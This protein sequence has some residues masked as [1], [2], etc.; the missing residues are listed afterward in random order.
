MRLRRALIATAVAVGVVSAVA[1][2]V[3]ATATTGD[4]CHGTTVRDV[5]VKKDTG[6]GTPAEWANL[7]LARTVTITCTGPDSYA[8][9]LVDRGA[10]VTIKG[11]GTPSGAG[12]QIEHTLPGTVYGVYH[13]TA[14]GTLAVPAHRDTMAGSS[15]YVTLLFDK[16]ST[17]TGGTYNW[18]YTVCSGRTVERWKDGTATDDGQSADAGNITAKYGLCLRHHPKPPVTPTPSPTDTTPAPGGEAPP[19]T[20]VKEQPNFT[21]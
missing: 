3:A 21:G 7:K 10:L 4:T 15:A 17:V 13:L 5:V 2:P 8:V 18:T 6:H 12:G 9:T 1:A 20:P 19:A 16:D 14:T 11:A